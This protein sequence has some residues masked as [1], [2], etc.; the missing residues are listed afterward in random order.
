VEGLIV[1]ELADGSF[2]DHFSEG[3]RLE[4]SAP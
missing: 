4:P 3:L 2:R 1:T